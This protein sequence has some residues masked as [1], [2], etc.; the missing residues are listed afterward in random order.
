MPVLEKWRSEQDNLK[1][2]VQHLLHKILPGVKS[3]QKNNTF[4]E[5]EVLS[6]I[7]RE[8]VLSTCKS[9]AFP[10][11]SLGEE[12]TIVFTL[13]TPGSTAAH[14]RHRGTR[15]LG[16]RGTPALHRPAP[17]RAAIS[18]SWGAAVPTGGAHPRGPRNK[19]SPFSSAADKRSAALWSPDTRT[20]ARWKQ[21]LVFLFFFKNY[22]KSKGWA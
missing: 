15:G 8:K 6:L 2:Q 10:A 3:W 11:L 1:H 7:Q 5:K 16:S 4:P 19:A 14:P 12:T 17:D 20:R 18:T 9:S 22:C 21:S 13:P